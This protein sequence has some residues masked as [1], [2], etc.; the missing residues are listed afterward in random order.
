[1]HLK[2]LHGLYSDS[3]GETGE[4]YCLEIGSSLLLFK[5]ETV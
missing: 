3:L 4:Q 1:M 2:S 5:K